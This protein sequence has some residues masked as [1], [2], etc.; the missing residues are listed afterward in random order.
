MCRSRLRGPQPLAATSKR[1]QLGVHTSA[2]TNVRCRRAAGLLPARRPLLVPGFRAPEWT[3]LLASWVIWSTDS[4]SGVGL[5]LIMVPLST[6]YTFCLME[7]VVPLSL[8][9]EIWGSWIIHEHD[10]SIW[11]WKKVVVWILFLK[12]WNVSEHNGCDSKVKERK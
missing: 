12:A 11:I 3:L 9:L 8:L 4:Y 7:H 2:G 6:F 5:S 1:Q 10:L